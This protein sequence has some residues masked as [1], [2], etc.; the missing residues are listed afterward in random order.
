MSEEDVREKAYTLIE[1]LEDELLQGQ[2]IL[3][4]SYS[5]NLDND[6]LLSKLHSLLACIR[7]RQK[8]LVKSKDIISSLLKQ[9]DESWIEE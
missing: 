3:D 4:N 1:D 2:F 8:N 5:D 6:Q 9:T 7:L